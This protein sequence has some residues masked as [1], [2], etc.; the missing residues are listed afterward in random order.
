MGN[1]LAQKIIISRGPDPSGN[2]VSPVEI[3]GPLENINT[4]A[5]VISIVL[6]FLY[7]LATILLFFFLM[8]GGFD[9][10]T[11]HGDPEKVKAGK[12]KISAAVTGFILLLLSFFVVKLLAVIFGLSSGIL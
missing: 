7:P 4:V 3:Y 1:D 9:F 6:K 10:M 11:S 8:W 2:P 12:A 5:D